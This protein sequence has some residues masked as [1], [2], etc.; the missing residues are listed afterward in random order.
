M[1]MIYVK[2]ILSAIAALFS[3][4][5]TVAFMGPFKGVSEQRAV[6]VAALAGG[7]VETCSSPVFWVVTMLLFAAIFA[8]SQIKNQILQVIVFWIPTLFVSTMAF[9]MALLIT[10]GVLHAAIG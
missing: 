3:S 2:S 4:M 6:G 1:P 9:G 10:V 8:A 7:L 5:L